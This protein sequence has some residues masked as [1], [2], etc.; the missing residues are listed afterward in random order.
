MTFRVVSGCGIE[1]LRLQGNDGENNTTDVLILDGENWE[2]RRRGIA[3]RYSSED[4]FPGEASPG[5]VCSESEELFRQALV[6]VAHRVLNPGHRI[7][8][9]VLRQ[10]IVDLA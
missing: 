1:R 3:L 4:W 6:E 5:P 9:R 7:N 2:Q 10:R 8:H